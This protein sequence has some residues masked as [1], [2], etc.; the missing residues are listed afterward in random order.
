MHLA[1]LKKI[2]KTSK[3]CYFWA[4]PVQKRGHHGPQLQ[5]KPYF[6]AQI[7]TADHKSSKKNDLIKKCFGCVI[8]LFL[9]NVMFSYQKGLFPAETADKK[10]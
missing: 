4:Q 8:N 7:T 3:N 1:V 2:G 10:N 5:Q 9:F 6:F